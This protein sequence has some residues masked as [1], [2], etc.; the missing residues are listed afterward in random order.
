[1]SF[2]AWDNMQQLP[3][4]YETAGVILVDLENAYSPP[5]IA[6]E[7]VSFWRAVIFETIYLY[8]GL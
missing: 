4:W 1:M 3:C 6:I 7:E 8:G 5:E 2:V